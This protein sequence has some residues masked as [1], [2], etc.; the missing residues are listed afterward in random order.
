MRTST[1]GPAPQQPPAQPSRTCTRSSRPRR[2]TSARSAPSTPVASSRAARP[3]RSTG[4]TTTPRSRGQTVTT[5]RRAA[6]IVLRGGPRDGP[7]D[8]SSE[9]GYAPLG[10]P[11]PTLGAPRGTRGAPRSPGTARER[12]LE[13]EDVARRQRP[14]GLRLTAVHQQHAVESG[15]DAEAT[16]HVG[17]AAALGHVQDGDT[18]PAAGREKALEGREE[19]DLDPH[20]PQRSAVG[21]APAT[22]RRSPGRIRSV[23]SRRFQRIT[24]PTETP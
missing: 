19:P 5:S 4:R 6:L 7:P 23:L 14:L 8:P 22:R 3:P 24:S 18:V 1:F 2:A 10:L 21:R 13:G 12:R 17:R 20:R 16:R 11:R 15:G 9:R